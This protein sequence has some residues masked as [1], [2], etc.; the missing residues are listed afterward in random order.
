MY[1]TRRHDARQ[2]KDETAIQ[3]RKTLTVDNTMLYAV[4]SVG[5]MLPLALVA[6]SVVWRF[7]SLRQ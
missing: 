5:E 2:R 6:S 7:A 4:H 3:K 1:A